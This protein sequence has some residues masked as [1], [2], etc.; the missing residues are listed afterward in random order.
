MN[1]RRE[2]ELDKC[3]KLFPLFAK[4]MMPELSLSGFHIKYYRILHRFATGQ[5]K[6]LIV[7]VP[8]QHGKSQGS[9]IFLPAFLLGL[10]PD[11]R[12]AIASYNATFAQKFN[13][14]V[15]RVLDNPLYGELFPL[16]RLNSKNIV[17]VANSYLRNSNEFE[18]VERQ[19]SLKAVGRGGPLT[20]NP[21]DVMIMDDLYK[22]AMEGN[23]PTIR[24]AVWDWY[25]SVVKTRLHNDS[26]ELIVF[27]RW[28][29]DDLIGRI[30]QK[31]SVVQ[32]NSFGDIDPDFKGWYKINFEAVKTGDPTEFD[33]RSKGE[34]L[35]PGRHSTELL[36]EKRSL[37]T[38]S[39]ECMYQG[40]PTAK[41]GLLYGDNFKTYEKIPDTINNSNYTD[42]ADMGN[43]YLCSVCYS[44]GT[45][46][47]V[48]VT[49]VLYTSEP[50]EITEPL[51]A[52]MFADNDTRIAHVESNNGGRG[53]A[54]N[55]QRLCPSVR[56]SW[57]TQS[58]NK[59]SRVLTNSATVLQNV[60]F[61]EDWRQRWPAFYSHLVNFK[62]E[63][64]ANSHDDAPD[65]LTGIVEKEIG[66]YNKPKI[67][68]I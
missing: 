29:E 8:P 37:D 55:L 41:E 20:G 53:F 10:N 2:V 62:R 47:F 61:P 24:E 46:G 34:P 64:R 45:D 42:T 6:K 13:R 58:G 1:Y 16:T 7:T 4:A 28:H 52:K 50:M 38:H 22:D 21:V 26:Q 17:T 25:T 65:C 18:I 60:L 56:V 19:G 48:Y 57:F 66:N 43:D 27:T 9:T 51:T 12:I 3:R 68:F 15:Q 67:I 54:R 32:L 40:N 5:I 33:S 36:I 35:W 11:L 59:E 23:S 31:E 44:V 30:S 39:F 63:F 49:D 14:N